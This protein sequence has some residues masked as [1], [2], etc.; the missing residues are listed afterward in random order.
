MHIPELTILF[1][2]L[3]CAM[4]V[5]IPVVL[6]IWFRRRG[7][8]VLPFFVGCLVMLVFAFVLE[9][10][11][12]AVVLNSDLGNAILGNV[13]LYAIYGGLLAG[14]FEESGRFLAFKTVLRNRREND[15][16]ALMFGAGHGG[17]E[18]FVVLAGSMSA[19]LM[20]ADMV[21]SGQVGSVVGGLPAEMITG[22]EAT[23][24]AFVATGPVDYLL[25]VIE[26][27]IAV[28]LH[29]SL[30]VL[31]WFAAKDRIRL[32]LFPLAIGIHAAV[33]SLVALGPAHGASTMQIEFI[34]AIL[35][36]L[37]AYYAWR[38]WMQDAHPIPQ[39]ADISMWS[40]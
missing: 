19:S 32:S 9:T 4:G 20:L 39:P 11:V 3:A 12:H 13:W 28:A 10:G 23:L 37:I 18:A 40:F 2:G 30:S 15:C 8:D 17:F 36:A 31:V 29:I 26:R 7:A 21:N 33:D 6:F 25:G 1:M 14:V 22:V 34:F 27:L 16:N 38:V 24:A 5:V 35:T